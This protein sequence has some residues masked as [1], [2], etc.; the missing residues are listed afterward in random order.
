M[1]PEEELIKNLVGEA[2]LVARWWKLS[3]DLVK[4]YQLHEKGS[5][6]QAVMGHV[7]H[8]GNNLAVKLEGEKCPERPKLRRELGWWSLLG[9]Y[10][11]WAENNAT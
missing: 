11:V 3:K 6:Q 4:Y 5:Y 2:V 1:N 9:Y 8:T 7:I 10:I